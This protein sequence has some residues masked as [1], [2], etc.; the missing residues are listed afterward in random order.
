M[1]RGMIDGSVRIRALPCSIETR[2]HS[3]AHNSG[4]R[5]RW[6]VRILELLPDGPWDQVALHSIP[7]VAISGVVLG[8]HCSD[9]SQWQF[10]SQ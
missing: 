4:S 5:Q 10:S 8:P 2:V 9:V 7:G 1:P 6:E 3:N